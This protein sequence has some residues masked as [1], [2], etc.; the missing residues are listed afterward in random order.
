MFNRA[1]VSH[2]FSIR[3]SIY[4][5]SFGPAHLISVPKKTL[6]AR[7]IAKTTNT[8]GCILHDKGNCTV[9]KRQLTAP[10][11]RTNG[12]VLTV[13]SPGRRLNTPTEESAVCADAQ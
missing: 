10:F 13:V 4:E 8:A 5:S 3:L 2:R 9:T 6:I 1:R 7:L 11:S 12:P